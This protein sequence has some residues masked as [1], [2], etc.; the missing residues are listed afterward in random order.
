MPLDT[1]VLNKL[2]DLSGKLFHGNDVDNR[3]LLQPVSI[4][5]EL[6]IRILDYI[7]DESTH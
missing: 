5:F 6:A 7:K 1:G 2:T 3:E 4:L